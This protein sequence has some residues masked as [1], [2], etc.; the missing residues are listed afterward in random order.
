MAATGAGPGTATI[1]VSVV[2]GAREPFSGAQILYRCI[3]GNQRERVSQFLTASDVRFTDLPVFDN[4]GDNYRVIVSTGGHEQAGVMGVKVGAGQETSVALL[5]MP[6]DG[7]YNFNRARWESLG[8]IDPKLNGIFASD[9]A[10]TDAAAA[11]WTDKFERES[12]VAA[13]LLNIL[14][15]MARTTI[16]GGQQLLG[17][18]GQVIWDE[19]MKQD[20]LFAWADKEVIRR[21]REPPETPEQVRF[22]PADSSL[23]PGAT[24]SVKS[25]QY[26]EANLQITFH[27]NDAPPEG[28]PEWVK[29]ELDIDYFADDITHFFLEVLRNR[30]TGSRTDPA[31][32]MALRWMAERKAGR[33]FDPLYTVR[34][35]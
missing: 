16:A 25:K 3:D 15:V 8:V 27:E 7:V 32:V 22:E 29:L 30:A 17:F 1:R 23:H 6:K 10:S 26:A 20:R 34:S 21:L 19:K 24:G 4:F 5:L 31:Y 18:L 33:G 11:R 12:P 13:C 9:L 2:N 35:A 28:H 14:T